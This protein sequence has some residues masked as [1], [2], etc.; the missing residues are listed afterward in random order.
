MG[1]EC[2][3]TRRAASETVQ[4]AFLHRC[5]TRGCKAALRPPQDAPSP[6]KGWFCPLR[7]IRKI[8]AFPRFCP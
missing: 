4:D 3:R 6:R 7:S 8:L 5:C 2:L 1:F